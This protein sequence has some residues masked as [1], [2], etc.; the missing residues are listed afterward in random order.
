M[1]CPVCN[2]EMDVNLRFPFEQLV[3]ENEIYLKK[4]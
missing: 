3:K 4:P 2:E 1:Y